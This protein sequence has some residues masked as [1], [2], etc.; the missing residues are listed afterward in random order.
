MKPQKKIQF[1]LIKFRCAKSILS[2]DLWRLFAFEFFTRPA[3][4][5]LVH[6][7]GSRNCTLI[8]K[9]CSTIK[10]L[11]ILTYAYASKK[12]P[13]RK[14]VY[15]CDLMECSTPNFRVFRT[16]VKPWETLCQQPKNKIIVKNLAKF[17]WK[18]NIKPLKFSVYNF[19]FQNKQK[20]G[21]FGFKGFSAHTPKNKQEHART[22]L[23]TGRAKLSARENWL[24][25]LQEGIWVHMKSWHYF[26]EMSDWTYSNW[27]CSKREKRCRK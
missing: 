22:G 21:S 13:E 16:V 26:D 6:K 11:C 18:K 7:F 4:H 8:I 3:F 10:I 1:L 23:G 27:S 9:Q 24:S 15:A 20:G 14:N 25:T 5:T 17:F 19:L 12:V 2:T